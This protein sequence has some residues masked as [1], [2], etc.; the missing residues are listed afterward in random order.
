MKKGEQNYEHIFCNVPNI[1][2][3]CECYILRVLTLTMT[4]KNLSYNSVSLIG[5]P[6]PAWTSMITKI[7][8]R[9]VLYC[10][11]VELFTSELR[12]KFDAKRWKLKEITWLST[13]FS[14]METDWETFHFI[15]QPPCWHTVYMKS[16][17]FSSQ[18]LNINRTR[19]GR[20]RLL[21]LYVAPKWSLTSILGTGVDWLIRT[22]RSE[23]ES[24]LRK[25]TWAVFATNWVQ[26]RIWG[27][28][29][30]VFR[31]FC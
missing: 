12:T 14:W 17:S 3:S 11:P 6:A 7:H 20:L 25:S 18:E 9:L 28:Y 13:Q 2:K 21:N 19:E 4:T 24:A 8:K 31:L 5:E 27:H 15:S 16:R 1:S 10:N 26:G 23:Q 29:C 22:G 30:G